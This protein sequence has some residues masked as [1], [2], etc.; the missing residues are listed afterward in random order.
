[1]GEL[2]LT[3]EIGLVC[4]SANSEYAGVLGCEEPFYKEKTRDFFGCCIASSIWIFFDPDQRRG[5]IQQLVLFVRA[6]MDAFP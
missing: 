1:M 4:L 6:G 2:A 3:H 5:R